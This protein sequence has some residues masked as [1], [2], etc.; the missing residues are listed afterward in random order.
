MPVREILL[1]K[2]GA[3]GDVVRTTGLLEPLRARHGPCRLSWLTSRGALP[4]LRGLPLDRTTALARKAPRWL[5]RTRFDLVVS[6]DEE[7]AA[8]RAAGALFT[9]RLV[10]AY[11][12]GDRVRYTPDSDPIFGMSLLAVDRRV[13]GARKQANRSSYQRLWARILGLSGPSSSFRPLPPGGARPGKPACG[14]RVAVH[15]GAG[16]RW[17]SK[18]LPDEAAAELTARLAR[19]GLSPLLITGPGERR[20]NESIV[21]KAG[22]GRVAPSMSLAAFSRWLSTCAAV[23]STDSLPM[24]LALA[25]GVPCVA[26]FGPTSPAEI[27]TFG[28]GVKFVPRRPCLCYYRPVCE[29]Q[30]CMGD[31]DLEAVVLETAR[32]V[33]R[34]NNSGS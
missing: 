17:S 10:G 26:L 1:I 24:H 34:G 30:P 22:A 4:L 28:L 19:A 15:I 25:A 13:A 31:L 8:A 11:L 6:M 16:P 32:L 5:A 29:A 33:R 3:M 12:E 18:R 14:L 9:R 27:E 2:L 21:R 20:R 7:R 23:V